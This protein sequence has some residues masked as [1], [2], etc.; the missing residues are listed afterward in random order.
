MTAGARVVWAFG[1]GIALV[2]ELNGVEAA[3]AGA[4]KPKTAV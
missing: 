2:K 1:N 3:A 4:E